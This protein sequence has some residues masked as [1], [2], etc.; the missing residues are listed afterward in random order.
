MLKTSPYTFGC[1]SISMYMYV[2]VAEF[3][4]ACTY[5]KD[6]SM[7]ASFKKKKKKW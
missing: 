7:I 4:Y 1:K 3:I 6:I 2:Y 5:C